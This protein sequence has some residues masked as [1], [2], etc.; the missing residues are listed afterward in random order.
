ML[1]TDSVYELFE[2]VVS[3]VPLAII[4]LGV[5]GNLTSFLIYTFHPALN[6]YSSMVFL[7]FIAILDTL[8]LFVWNLDHY[9]FI[10]FGFGIE[11]RNMV[12]CKFFTFL[13]Y[14]TLQTSGLLYSVISVDRYFTVI[15][16]PGSFI[17]KLPFGTRK[18]AYFMVVCNI[19]VH[20]LDKCSWSFL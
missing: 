13:Q 8:G 4:V 6:K 17:K 7:S 11:G 16:K 2:R 14:V 18:S 10:N 20:F 3:Y 9:L 1:A 12:F 15:S 19:D 5:F